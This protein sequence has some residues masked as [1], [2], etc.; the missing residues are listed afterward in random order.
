MIDTAKREMVIKLRKSG[1]TYNE[2]AKSMNMKNS[3]WVCQVCRENGC[4]G[5]ASWK[6][7]K[8]EAMREYKA[9]GHTN[10]EVALL[11]GV[12][13][14]ASQQICK[15][16]A[17]Q[18]A[19]PQEYRNGYSGIDKD[20]IGRKLIE[21]RAPE[22]EYVGGYTASDGF[23]D[24]RCKACGAVLRK[25]C[26]TIRHG[27][28]TCENCKRI[29][30]EQREK[31]RKIEADKEKWLKVGKRRAEQLSFSTC[32]CCGSL[33]MP[34]SKRNKYC[35][36][37]CQHKV[38]NAL[39]KDKRLHKIANAL[40]DRNIDLKQLFKRDGGLCS[41]CGKECR[42]DDSAV[43]DDGTFV[44]FKDYPSIDHIVPL[45]KG[46]KHEWTNVQLACRS[47]NSKKG[48]R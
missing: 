8:H 37:E 21:E 1:M 18:L 23:V 12:S 22:Y 33:F 32:E 40:V 46:G 6:D 15:G 38:L 9:Q 43:M 10:G 20:T 29:E 24:I 35:S 34:I 36:I 47:C 2:I 16:I 45:S 44:A 7:K 5:T 27:K 28:T 39:G 11:F 30:T 19:R 25:S 3:S 14:G 13:I 4:G 31:Q 48:A 41:I 17:P 26:V 42:W